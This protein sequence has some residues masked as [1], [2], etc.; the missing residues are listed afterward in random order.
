MKLSIVVPVYNVE[1]YLGECLESVFKQSF[2][3]YEIICVN[4]GSTDNSLSILEKYKTKHNN[5]RIVNQTNHGLGYAR[6]VGIEMA[7]GDYVAFLDSDDFIHKDM[8]LDMVNCIEKNNADICISNPYIYEHNNGVR[9]PYRKMLDFYRLSLLGCFKAIDYPI[10]FSY[11][12]AWDKI[13]K[14]SF[15]LKNNIRFPINRIYEDALFTYQVLAYA[16]GVC[17][18][19]DCYYFYRK[20]SGISITDKE[21]INDNYKKDFLTN[22]KEIKD[23]LK[24]MNIYDTVSSVF[25]KYVFHDG[26]FHHAYATTKVFFKEFFDSMVNLLD[27]NDYDVINKTRIKKYVWYSDVL[28][29]NKFKECKKR[30]KKMLLLDENILEEQKSE[31]Y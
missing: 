26:L 5:I 9:Y 1:N 11:I 8:F 30:I 2:Q 6:N 27:S 12:A 18:V 21:K 28:K 13:Y 24:K 4:D 3:D 20:N 16:K 23:F 15:L 22:S 7:S 25:I 10:V 29:N 17:A 19:K 14:R 31:K